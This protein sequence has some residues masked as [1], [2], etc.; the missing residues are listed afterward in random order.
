MI[1]VIESGVD[2]KDLRVNHRYRDVRKL[3]PLIANA[4]KQ[5]TKD[6]ERAGKA[7]GVEIPKDRRVRLKVSIWF[8]FNDMR[9]DVDGPSKRTLD[10]IAAG[11][12]FNDNRVDELTLVRSSV[13]PPGIVAVVETVGESEGDLVEDLVDDPWA[14]LPGETYAAIRS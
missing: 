5:L 13:G 11:L 4:M 10:A 1:V 9:A 2:P 8:T 7:T 12:E 14:I 6:A 3:P